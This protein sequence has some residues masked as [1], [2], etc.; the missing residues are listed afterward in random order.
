MAYIC[1]ECGEVF[2][3]P[4]RYQEPFSPEYGPYVYDICPRCGG[5]DIDV[6]TVCPKCGGR[7]KE[8]DR[9]CVNC[10]TSLIAK[11][12]NFRDYL[13]A[14]EEDTLD[15]WLDGESIKSV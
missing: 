1:N 13:T 9:L 6:I 2:S 11:F 5:E 7:K 14:E 12:R 4:A 15:D 10:K 3:A 8:T